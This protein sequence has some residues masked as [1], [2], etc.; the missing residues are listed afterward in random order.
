MSLRHMHVELGGGRGGKHVASHVRHVKFQQS[1]KQS[2]KLCC[3][4]KCKNEQKWAF[5]RL[6]PGDF[7]V[8]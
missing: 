1:V 6:P 8:L 2:N 3:I 7:L 4:S 5:V